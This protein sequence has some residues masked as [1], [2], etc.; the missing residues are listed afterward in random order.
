VIDVTQEIWANLS[1]L[2]PDWVKAE[3]ALGIVQQPVVLIGLGDGND[4][5]QKRLQRSAT[6][7]ISLEVSFN[8]NR[9]DV[10]PMNPAG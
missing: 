8:I 3:A 9:D 2:I 4:I 7:I 1:I 10:I 6:K 5:C